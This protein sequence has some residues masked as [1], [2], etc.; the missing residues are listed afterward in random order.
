MQHQQ[1][2]KNFFRFAALF[3]FTAAL[4]LLFAP[5]LFFSLLMMPDRLTMEAMPWIH[6][7]AVL[8]LAFG[9]GYWAISQDPAGKRDIIWMG[10]LGKV[11]VFS[12]AWIDFFFFELPIGFPLLVVADL[13]FAAVYFVFLRTLDRQ[14]QYGKREVI[15]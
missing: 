14:P 13:A 8:V 4:A 3:N 15:R 10:C 1:A 7:F 6:Q 5:S 9:V 11:L 12:M 2:W